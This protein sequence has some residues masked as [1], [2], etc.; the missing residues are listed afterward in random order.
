M[1]LKIAICDD[2]QIFLEKL[3]NQISVEFAKTDIRFH[4][5]SYM[6]GV[7]LLLDNEKEVYDLVFLDI[8]MPHINGIEV[9]EQIRQRNPYV[10]I[11]FIT[12]REDLVFQ[13]LRY[14]PF[15]FIRKSRIREELPEAVEGIIQKLNSENRYY[16]ITFNNS[17]IQLRIVDIIYIESMRHDIYFN[18][19]EQTYR[20]KSNLSKLEKEFETYGFI[21]VHSGFLVNYRYIYS[22]DKTKVVLNNK[23]MVPLSRHRIETVKQKLQLYARGIQ[24]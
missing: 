18:C 21:R 19:Q 1:V 5:T 9:A 15:R 22:I 13:S 16:T 24:G 14:R 6:N 11:I 7:K 20:V 3:L 12:N 23:E 2:E 17:P 4:F 10:S 8:E